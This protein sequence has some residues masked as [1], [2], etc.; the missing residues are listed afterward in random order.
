[1]EAGILPPFQCPL[2]FLILIH[3]FI[4]IVTLPFL[5]LF[6]YFPY[7]DLQDTFPVFLPEGNDPGIESRWITVHP[8]LHCLSVRVEGLAFTAQ[9]PE[10][11]YH[12][13]KK[14]RLGPAGS[15]MHGQPDQFDGIAD[16]H[17]P[18]QVQVGILLPGMFYIVQQADDGIILPVQ[19]L[20]R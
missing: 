3:P 9:L 14:I 17:L 12:V 5:S 16:G 13:L 10:Q 7:Q 2:Q 6:L 18:P 4:E 20:K 19:L 15:L 1:M 8:L 11:L